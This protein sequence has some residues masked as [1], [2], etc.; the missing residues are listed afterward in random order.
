MLL[1]CIFRHPFVEPA[2]V[3][4]ESVGSRLRHCGGEYD[5]FFFYLL[6]KDDCARRIQTATIKTLS[7]ELRSMTRRKD[8]SLFCWIIREHTITA[9]CFML[10]NHAIWYERDDLAPAA[11]QSGGDGN[12]KTDGGKR[13]IIRQGGSTSDEG[14]RQSLSKEW[15]DVSERIQTDMRDNVP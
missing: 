4:H 13:W 8:I 14:S 6:C 1:H 2:A 12:Q 10:T 15:K 11:T 9:D 3:D 5:Q 7:Q